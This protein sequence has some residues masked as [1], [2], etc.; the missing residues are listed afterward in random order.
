MLQGQTIVVTGATNGIGE[1]AATALAKAGA[2]IVIVSR[3]E[4]RCKETIARIRTA[5]GNDSLSYIAAD[6]SLLRDMHRTADTILERHDRLHVLLN[7]AGAFFNTREVTAD[8]YEKTFALNHMSYFVL[9]TRLLDLLKRTASQDGE[10]RVI[11]VSSGA[12]VGA[13]KGI[14]FDDIH[15]SKGYSGFGVYSE[16]K[17]MN[18]MFTYALARRLEGTDVTVNALHPGFVRTGFGMNNGGIV[19]TLLGLTQRFFALTPEQGAETSIYLASSPNIKGVTGKYFV[20][21][22]ERSSSSISYD[23]TQQERLWQLSEE[24]ASVKV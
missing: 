18:L 17:L 12:H 20:D 23:K 11:N 14:P 15:H 8:G 19:A 10:A 9:T 5:T 4:T 22:K 6:L 21:K 13:S 7:N 24:L 3:S 16:S 1:I 2:Q